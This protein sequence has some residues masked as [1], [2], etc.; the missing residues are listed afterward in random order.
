[1]RIK[2][3]DALKS[4]GNQDLAHTKDSVDSF[5]LQIFIETSAFAKK[6]LGS[7]IKQETKQF[8]GHFQSDKI[9]RVRT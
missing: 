7:G 4:S 1:M 9:V 5:I 2:L 8:Y 3:I 6:V